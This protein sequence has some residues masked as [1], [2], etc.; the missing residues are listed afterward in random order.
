MSLVA[1]VAD[2]A[3]EFGALGL[4]SNHGS[5]FELT[6]VADG[7]LIFRDSVISSSRLAKARERI[8][9]YVLY[10]TIS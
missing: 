10:F 9:T 1:K 8:S 6:S 7:D 4:R 5:G 2:V 3:T